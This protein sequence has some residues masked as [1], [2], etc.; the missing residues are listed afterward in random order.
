LPKELPGLLRNSREK[1]HQQEDMLIIVVLTL[2]SGGFS[3]QRSQRFD[4]NAAD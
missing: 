1:G 3:N 4:L 2:V